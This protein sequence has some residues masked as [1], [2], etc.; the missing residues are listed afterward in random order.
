VTFKEY[1]KVIDIPI[2][3]IKYEEAFD[4]LTRLDVTKTK[5]E[6]V[7]NN[8]Q[9]RRPNDKIEIEGGELYKPTQKFINDLLDE[10]FVDNFDIPVLHTLIL[11]DDVTNIIKNQKDPMIS[12]ILRNRHCRFT[13]FFNIHNFTRNG[14]PTE[15]KKSMRSL[16]YFGGYSHQDFVSSYPQMKCNHL[17]S[18]EV[19]EMYR[20]LSRYDMLFFDFAP[21]GTTVKPIIL[22]NDKKNQVKFNN[23][24]SIEGGKGK[25][26]EKNKGFNNKKGL[27]VMKIKNKN[28]K[29]I[30]EQDEDGDGDEDGDSDSNSDDDDNESKEIVMKKEE[31]DDAIDIDEDEFLT[32]ATNSKK[33]KK[34]KRKKKKGKR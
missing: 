34:G 1:S 19:W 13:Y 10:L 33:G 18:E 30:K 26:K 28:E 21:K 11:Y 17:R 20:H 22:L 15:I 4:Y 24:D 32:G 31:L 16:W 23:I 8:V 5:Y 27:E 2:K 12:F 9:K 14:I 3:G 6:Q 7:A 29:M 25:E